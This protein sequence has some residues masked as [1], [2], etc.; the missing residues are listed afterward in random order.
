MFANWAVFLVLV[1]RDGTE[2]P[3]GLGVIGTICLGYFVL[4]GHLVSSKHSVGA[5]SL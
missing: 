1:D 2:S 5:L 3:V 4:Y